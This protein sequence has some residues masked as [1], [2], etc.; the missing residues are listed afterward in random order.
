[1]PLKLVNETVF[2]RVFIQINTRILIMM[3]ET[4]PI[5]VVLMMMKKIG[6]QV[7]TTKRWDTFDYVVAVKRTKVTVGVKL[8]HCEKAPNKY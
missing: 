4:T 2:L 7:N 8:L 5:I 6:R 3:A 1:M